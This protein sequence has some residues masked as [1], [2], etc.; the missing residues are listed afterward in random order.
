L[1]VDR[2]QAVRPD[3]QVT[4]ANA[5]AVAELCRR[6]E[7]I[8]LA[9]ELA[10]SRA[11]VLTPAQIVAQLARRFDFLVSRR[12]DATPRHRSLRAAI[13]W[14]YQ[15][16][17]PELQR[18]FA[19]LS[20]FRGGWTLEAA[21]AVCSGAP[22]PDVLDYLAQLRECTLVL[23]E[24]SA[25]GMR[26]RMLETLREFAAEQQ[27]PEERTELERRH[28]EYYMALAAATEVRL[29]GVLRHLVGPPYLTLEEGE[30]LDCLAVEQDNCRAALAWALEREPE[31]AL[32]FA[33]ALGPFWELDGHYAEGVEGLQ[34]ARERCPEG[35][36]PLRAKA[37][38]WEGRLARKQGDFPRAKGP[39]EESVDLSRELGDPSSLAE[40]LGTLGWLAGG[41]GDPRCRVLYEESLALSCASGDKKGIVSA[42]N[43]LAHCAAYLGDYATAHVRFKES[44]EI[45]REL[46]DKPG[47]ASA[48]HN[49]GILVY[50][51]GD[52]AGA[53]SLYER[54][55]AISRELAG[56]A[57]GPLSL[58]HY[59]FIHLAHVAFVQREYAEA[60]TLLRESL[61]VCR[62]VGD[63]R[64]VEECV[65]SLAAVAATQNQPERAARLFAAAASLRQSM[66]RPERK[67]Y[68]R[69][70]AAV[71]EALGKARFTAAWDAGRV[72]TWQQAADE[73]LQGHQE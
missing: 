25:M 36:K 44:L 73:T 37:L 59:T 12:R 67:Q 65:E 72:L 70:F 18:F 50:A 27:A 28:A 32:R 11:Q 35:P 60:E 48:L 53:R 26:F 19:R 21:E 10:A 46:G 17:A 55:M 42:L 71:R 13:D 61:A 41:Q 63:K 5:G 22:D 51:E 52:F 57:R 34:H 64:L 62:Q 40:K 15:L 2:A 3:F 39:L 66:G 49:Q 54:S 14:S 8:P 33:G 6:L 20:V 9:I 4:A 23:A 38:W 69:E 68:D 29:E 30:W 47:I 24:E 45:S 1:L 56:Q 58:F 31:F 16:L 7:G 43:G